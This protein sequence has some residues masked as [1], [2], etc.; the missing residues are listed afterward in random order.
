MYV[1][2]GGGVVDKTQVRNGEFGASR[3]KEPKFKQ[4]T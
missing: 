1:G 2:G 4:N 3:N